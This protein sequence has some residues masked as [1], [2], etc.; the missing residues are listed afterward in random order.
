MLGNKIDLLIMGSS[1][2]Q[3]LKYTIDSFT[4]FVDFPSDIVFRR[5]FHEDI[6]FEK[7]SLISRL[8]ARRAGCDIFHHQPAVGLSISM[9]EMFKEISSKY[10]FY[11]QD[12]WEFERTID[13]DRIVWTM[14]R[15][16]EIN[17]VFFSHQKTD[18]YHDF[19]GYKFKNKEMD[20]DGLKLCTYNAWPFLP[21]IWRM[22][23]IKKYWYDIRIDRPEGYFTNLFGTPEQRDS[24][25][26]CLKNIG[27]FYYGNMGDYRYTRHIGGTWRMAKWQR[28]EN[29]QPTGDPGY[30]LLGL[31]Q[32]APWLNEMETRPLYSTSKISNKVRK[33]LRVEKI[34]KEMIKKFI[35]E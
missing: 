7:R 25:E 20:F 3:L 32:R 29:G 5:L 35:K 22:D 4:K 8:F 12:D 2:P 14:D 15:H 28:D 24:N 27:S 19:S 11:L 1:R 33:R 23:V 30:D 13:I 34:P 9:T 26:Y 17:L 6:I 31:K 18:K 10:V 16:P 21:G